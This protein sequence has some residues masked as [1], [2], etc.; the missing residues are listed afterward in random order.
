MAR[1]P[2]VLWIANSNCFCGGWVGLGGGGDEGGSGRMESHRMERS[3]DSRLESRVGVRA[4]KERVMV[5]I[6]CG[7][8]HL[9]R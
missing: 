6:V 3:Q 8:W 5:E 4:G 1:R 9:D 2:L 7:V